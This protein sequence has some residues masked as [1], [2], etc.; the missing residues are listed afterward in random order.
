MVRIRK[1]N[2][3][4]KDRQ[5]KKALGCGLVFPSVEAI[6]LAGVLGGFDYV[7]LDAEHGHFSLES[8]DSMCRA[9][10]GYGLTVTARVPSIDSLIINTYLDRGIMGIVAPHIDTPEQAKAVVRGC[11]F[12]PKGERSWGGWRGTYFSDA[13][14]LQVPASG[15]TE[16]MSQT[17][18]EMLV[19]VMI[20]TTTAIENLDALLAV[21]G[22][23]AF[24]FGPNDLSQ[25]MG[26]P[27][28]PNHPRVIE[29][30]RETTD[31][32]HAAGR[33]LLGD[34]AEAVEVSEMILEGYRKFLAENQ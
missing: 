12:A 13:G 6:E 8:I 14:L 20:E 22:V 28:Q 34:M 24:L 21:D 4:E 32:I 30:V 1:N 3:R 33:K 29:A 23:D 25:S 31:R 15:N 16:F 2:I 7:Y 27:G 18:A 10:D 11:R 9:A 17:N 19:V 26:L 5:G